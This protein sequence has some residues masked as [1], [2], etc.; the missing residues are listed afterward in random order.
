MSVTSKNGFRTL[1]V[2]STLTGFGGLAD[3]IF[4]SLLSPE[5]REY[6]SKAEVTSYG[7]FLAAY[8][9]LMSFLGIVAFIGV[10]M[11]RKWARTLSVILTVIGILF[12]PFFTEQISSGLSAA[13]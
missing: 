2:L 6:F 12:L 11:F 5:L 4:P 1:L 9:F 10:L 7:K 13:F 3:V 8:T